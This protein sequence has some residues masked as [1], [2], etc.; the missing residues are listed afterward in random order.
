MLSVLIEAVNKGYLGL[1]TMV[2][3]SKDVA[4]EH[5]AER[6]WGDVQGWKGQRLSKEGKE[7]LVKSVIQAVLAYTTSCVSFTKFLK[8]LTSVFMLWKNS[9]GTYAMDSARCIG[10]ARRSSLCQRN[11]EV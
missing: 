6:D 10:P 11:G 8:Q 5:I 7:I 3:R 9:G 2:G 1:P 4:F